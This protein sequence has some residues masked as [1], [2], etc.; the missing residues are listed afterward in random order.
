MVA[1]IRELVNTLNPSVSKETIVN[2]MVLNISNRNMDIDTPRKR[3]AFSSVNN[4]RVLST[5]SDVSSIP[6]HERMEVQSNKLTWD[7]QVEINEREN[8]SL[9]YTT[10]KIGESVPAN[11]TIDH[12]LKNRIQHLNNEVSI[13]SNMPTPQG[14]GEVLNII[15]ICTPQAIKTSSIPYEDN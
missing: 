6:Y 10:P 8:F 2:P 13:L 5:H 11:K 12:N 14:E 1:P 3:L 7:K 15:N 4:S 9:S